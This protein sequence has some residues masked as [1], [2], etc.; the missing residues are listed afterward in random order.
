MYGGHFIIEEMQ[1]FGTI[2]LVP[3][4]PAQPVVLSRFIHVKKNI[5]RIR[6]RVNKIC[7]GQ[8]LQACGL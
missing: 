2:R 6:S 1:N 5:F 4:I 8:D 3:E 7:S